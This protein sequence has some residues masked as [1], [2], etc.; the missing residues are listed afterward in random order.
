[1]KIRLMA[2]GQDYESLQVGIFTPKAVEVNELGVGEVGFLVANI[3]KISDAKIGDTITET[4]R[5][6]ARA[7]PG[8]Q[9]AEADGLRRALSGRGPRIPRA[10]RRAREA[11]G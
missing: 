5:P 7:V 11:A 6:T 2:E 8:L 4:G 1:M 10:A 3:K 9:G